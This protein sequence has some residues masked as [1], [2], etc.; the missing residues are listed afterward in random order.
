MLE[1]QRFR[2]DGAD[3]TGAEEFREGD[4]QVNREEKQ[5]AH[6]CNAITPAVLR[7]T[8]RK[9]ELALRFTNSP[10]TPYRND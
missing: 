10:P 6:G 4:E 9:R 8:A 2:G 5:F 7:K 3:A 1:Q